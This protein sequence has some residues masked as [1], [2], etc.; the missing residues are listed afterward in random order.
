MAAGVRRPER[1]GP[2]TSANG[3]DLGGTGDWSEVRVDA[4][5]INGGGAFQVG[6]RWI[7]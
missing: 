1:G 6:R 2:N 4:I 5:V 3:G 7:S